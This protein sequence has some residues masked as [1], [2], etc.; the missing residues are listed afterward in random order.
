MIC[1]RATTSA[2]GYV[3]TTGQS[4]IVQGVPTPLCFAHPQDFL[5]IQVDAFVCKNALYFVEIH[6][7]PKAIVYSDCKNALELLTKE[8]SDS[9]SNMLYTYRL[10]QEIPIKHCS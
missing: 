10:R 3:S 4:R 8:H 5:M 6:N 9:Y 7:L 2:R 1:F